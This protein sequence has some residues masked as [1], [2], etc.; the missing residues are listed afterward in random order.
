[1]DYEQITAAIERLNALKSKLASGDRSARKESLQLS[2]KLTV[3]LEE[4]ANAAVSLA[5]APFITIAARISIG[6][7]LFKLIANH[8]GPVTSKE[9]ALLSGGEELLII[10]I[11]RV[12]ASVSFVE[13]VGENTWKAT[14]ITMVMATDEIAAG[15]RVFERAV[16]AGIKANKYFQEAGYR[17]PVNPSDSFMQY[18]YQSKLP[19]FQIFS[20]FPGLS[21]DF[22]D[23][24][25]S[26]MGARESWVKWF[27]VEDRL[28][29]GASIT[30][31]NPYLLIDVGGGKGHDT[32]AF[33]QRFPNQKGRLVVQDLSVV[34]DRVP[35]T[36]E[37]VEFMVYDFFTE[38]PIKGARS[39]FYHHILHNWSDQQC[40][41]I[42]EPVKKAMKPGYSK[43]LLHEMIMPDQGASTF[44]TMLDMTMMS[45]NLGMERTVAQW[46]R[47]LEAAGFTVVKFW[48][49]PQDDGDGI[50]EAMLRE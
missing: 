22:D 47:L 15:H 18:A 21:E 49:P 10:R 17:L 3:Q 48:L 7:G 34:I 35:D 23:Y 6:L 1:M 43:L 50:I 26:A 9:L 14:P 37:A 5:V 33:H 42:L 41:E 36:D 13:E 45:F 20:I 19:G 4:P 11:L 32:V 30:E 38:Q 31:E 39:Y 16:G 44:H 25:V 24:M 46:T 8:N 40:M 12:L 29:E 2:Q 28:I 27:P